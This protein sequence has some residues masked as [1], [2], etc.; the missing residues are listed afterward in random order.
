MDHRPPD[1]PELADAR[2][3]ARQG[4]LDGA[5]E[6]ARA[7]LARAPSSRELA[8]LVARIEGDLRALA[9]GW[10]PALAAAGP[11][12]RAEPITGRVMM[13]VS[14]ALPS[15]SGGS[16]V[17][18]HAVALAQRSAGLDPVV[19]VRPGLPE[20][21]TTPVGSLDGI[22][23]RWL[24]P[25]R[26]PRRP[27]DQALE[28]FAR[29]AAAEAAELRPAV[30]HTAETASMHD[31]T[32]QVGMAVA[33][34]RDI[35]M[36]FEV[37]GFREESWLLHEGA[38]TEDSQMYRMARASDTWLMEHADA[39]VTLSHVMADQVIARGIPEEH[40]TVVPN[41]V[42][43][44]RYA[45]RPRDPELAARLGIRDDEVVIGFA[46]GLRRY[47]ALP[48]LVRAFGQVAGR[49][50]SVRLLLVGEGPVEDEVRGLVAELDLSDRVLMPGQVPFDSMVDWY[51]LMDVIATARTD[52]R[53]A[54]LVSPTKPLEAMAMGRALVVSD[55]P[56][57]MEMVQPERTALV[58][59]PGSVGSLAEA[60]DRLASDAALRAR[61][62]VA[63][64][65]WVMAERSWVA[66]GRTYRDLFT[67]LGAA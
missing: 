33:R 46:G 44:E 14:T 5:L 48:V 31:T 42:D 18:T 64:R 38:G 21:A 12:D 40:V 58:V 32:A 37:R 60:L 50:R 22:P 65:A 6:A 1:P 53:V 57:L 45:P 66:N 56:A 26:L 36:V 25:G 55:T 62:G 4:D 47:E 29:I 39:V 52:D 35:P 2:R 49:D 63:A 54:R 30:V 19:V 23:H 24:Q 59:E 67:R 15:H 51:S 8:R 61:L 10:L 3:L 34:A 20:D 27:Q 7:G 13:L 9:P 28:A 11:A 43:A 16:G 41:A 17:R